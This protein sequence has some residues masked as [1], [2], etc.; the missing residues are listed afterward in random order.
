MTRDELLAE[1]Q[2][3]ARLVGMGAERET[4]LKAQIDRLKRVNAEMLEALTTLNPRLDKDSDMVVIII[5]KRQ[6]DQIQMAIA[7]AR[8][9]A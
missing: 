5:S 6:R 9:A 4:A 3:Q 8:D 1:L 2:E 7:K